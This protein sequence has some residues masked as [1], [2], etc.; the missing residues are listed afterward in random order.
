MAIKHLRAKL[1]GI[2]VTGSELDYHGSITLDPSHCNMVTIYPLEFVE[3]WNKNN[4]ERFST[5]VIYGKENSNCCILNGSAARKC[6]IGDE[7]IIAAYEFNE[8]SILTKIS[9]KVLTF[10]HDN[11]IEEIL[12]Y[13]VTI[14]D[15]KY[16][17][18]VNKL[19]T[20]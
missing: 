20:K 19:L 1:H 17:F 16:F 18:S 12:E 3:I 7:L 5:Y 14:Q 8:C 13:N 6:Q 15:K 11:S 9:P 2:K 4:G 10:N